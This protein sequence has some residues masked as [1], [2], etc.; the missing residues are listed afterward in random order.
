MGSGSSTYTYDGNGNQLTKT[1]DDGTAEFAYNVFNQQTQY[2]MGPVTAQYVYNADG[3]RTSKT[4]NGQ[5]TTFLLDG[6][7][8]A[9]EVQDDQVTATYLRGINLISQDV[10]YDRF[11]YQYNAHGDVVTLTDQTGSVSKSYDYTAFGIESDPDANDEN[12]FRYCGEYFDSETGTY[13]LR[14]RYY[15]PSIGRF[16]QPDSH[17]NSANRIYG[18][19]PQ[20]INERED[21]LG[22]KLYSYRPQISAI[23]QSGNLYAYCMNNPIAFIDRSGRNAAALQWVPSLS[24]ALPW[25]IDAATAGMT[26]LGTAIVSSWNPP[27]AAI[28]ATVAIGALALVIDQAVAYA[29]EAEQAKAWVNTKISAR[30]LSSKD[31][32]SNSVYVIVDRSYQQV[33]YVGITRNFSKRQATH[34]S[35]KSAKYPSAE[36]EMI[37]VATGMTRNEARALEQALI[38]AYT[39]EALN[40]MIN[41][42]AP[43]KWENFTYEFSRANSLISGYFTD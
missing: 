39:L 29:A 23:V 10:G 16:T 27:V 25:I 38:T 2:S 40:N 5:R 32:R 43:S 14:A 42:I 21:A 37:P 18:D 15:D 30:S 35:G 33:W 11:Y 7:N 34:Q 31:L 8:V 9:A 19:D 26:S 3:I 41:S 22:N 12:P 20:K 28:A 6:G 17:W 24:D 1:T 4:V 36:Y 13:Y